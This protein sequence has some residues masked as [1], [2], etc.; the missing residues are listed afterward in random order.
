[1]CV[2]AIARIPLRSTFSGPELGALGCTRCVGFGDPECIRQSRKQAH[3]VISDISTIETV[4]K[5]KLDPWQSGDCSLR[6]P[7]STVDTADTEGCSSCRS[8]F[9]DKCGARFLV[10]PPPCCTA[11]ATAASPWSHEP[12]ENHG[13]TPSNAAWHA[14]AE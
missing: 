8:M 14:H 12:G 4:V 9:A 13:R 1:M 5:E 2:C 6:N 3:R 7:E 11:L 10:S